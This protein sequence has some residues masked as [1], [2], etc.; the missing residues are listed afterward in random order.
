MSSAH[1]SELVEPTSIQH[2][3]AA[4]FSCPIA[5]SAQPQIVTI[6]GTFLEVYSVAQVRI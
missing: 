3:V 6:R 4:Y 1:Y 5:Y 2:C